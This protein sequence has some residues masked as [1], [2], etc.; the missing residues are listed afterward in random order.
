MIIRGKARRVSAA[1]SRRHPSRADLPLPRG[2]ALPPS[3]G[4]G[5]PSPP[6]VLWFSPIS[7]TNWITPHIVYPPPPQ[8]RSA[9]CSRAIQPV[10]LP[11]LRAPRRGAL[12]PLASRFF[13]T[14]IWFP[15]PFAAGI[16]GS[17]MRTPRACVRACLRV[18]CVCAR[19][20]VIIIREQLYIWGTNGLR[21]V[22]PM[23]GGAGLILYPRRF[24]TRGTRQHCFILWRD[25]IRTRNI[26]LH[27]TRAFF[28]A[29]RYYRSLHYSRSG[30]S[31]CLIR[32]TCF[33][34]GC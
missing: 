28:F 6:R 27:G 23:L 11:T 32:D 33:N 5:G 25:R 30:A 9:W 14:L 8:V 26:T 13:P 34:L 29:E 16:R 12:P 2:A 17:R 3:W 1:T 15:D 18:S 10:F 22:H 4:G 31:V 21:P 7:P 19:D 24:S 20:C